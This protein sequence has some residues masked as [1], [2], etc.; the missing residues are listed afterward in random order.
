MNKHHW[1]ISAHN[2]AQARREQN[3]KALPFSHAFSGCNTVSSVNGIGKKKAWKTWKTIPSFTETFLELFNSP[4]NISERTLGE[5]ER[6]VI[7]MYNRASDCK[8]VNEARKK[9]F[10]KGRQIQNI[11][12]AQ[13]AL[14]E[15]TKR[16]AY[17]GGYCWNRTL[18]A[19]EDLPDSWRC[20]VGFCF[21]QL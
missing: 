12:S 21:G 5:T 3:A 11:P 20:H 10:A 7:I 19:K 18:M 17:Q 13:A 1:L 8:L 14:T 9:M 16:T 2:I 6:F 15:H 4:V